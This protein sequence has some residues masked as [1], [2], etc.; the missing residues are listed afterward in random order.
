MGHPSQG[1][2]GLHRQEKASRQAHRENPARRPHP[3]QIEEKPCAIPRVD[4][5]AALGGAVE[6]I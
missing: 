4:P 2:H 6:V 5:L 3:A 1:H